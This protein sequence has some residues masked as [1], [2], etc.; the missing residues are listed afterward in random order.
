MKT[1]FY[2]ASVQF[3]LTDEEFN[4]FME[5]TE[6]ASRVYI[7]R[8]GAY[9]SNKFI[10]AGNKP[11]DPNVRTCRDGS[12]A[13][14]KFGQWVDAKDNAVIMDLQYYPELLKEYEGDDLQI[15]NKKALTGN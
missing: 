14:K 11:A 6:K 5:A 10:W 15:D 12:V 13:I 8:L 4:S 2:S 1:V 9:L 3:E 7:K